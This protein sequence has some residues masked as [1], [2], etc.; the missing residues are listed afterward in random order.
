MCTILKRFILKNGGSIWLNSRSLL[1][2]CK[3]YRYLFHLIMFSLNDQ[4]MLYYIFHKWIMD[5]YIF[6][7]FIL[8]VI[9][10]YHQPSLWEITK[11]YILWFIHS[12]RIFK[13]KNHYV[14][15]FTIISK[16]RSW[17]MPKVSTVKPA[18]QI[19]RWPNEMAKSLLS[20]SLDLVI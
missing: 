7:C 15:T 8:L 14:H 16:K 2:L 12:N 3:I 19:S 5:F 18:L 17:E 11:Q 10:V 9:R 6:L 13:F 1:R 20:S 4:L